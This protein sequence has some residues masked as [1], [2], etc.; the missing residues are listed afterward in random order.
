MNEFDIKHSII[1][2]GIEIME[3]I[4]TLYVNIGMRFTFFPLHTE[5]CGLASLNIL[6]MGVP[7]KNAQRFEDA[8]MGL[9]EGKF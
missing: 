1:H 5:D 6:H 9:I 4:N 8:I 2:S 3:G 7:R